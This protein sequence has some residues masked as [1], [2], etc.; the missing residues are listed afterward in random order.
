ME[1]L[2]ETFLWVNSLDLSFLHKTIEDSGWL[3]LLAVGSGG[4]LSAAVALADM[5][6]YWTGKLSIA[7]T[8]LQAATVPSQHEQIVWLLSASGNNVDIMSAFNSLVVRE[9]RKL[10]IICSNPDSKLANAAKKHRFTDSHIYKL[11][12]GKDGFLATNSLL[13][14]ASIFMKAY[15]SIFESS[16]KWN[17]IYEEIT[18]ILSFQEV[19]QGW[20]KTILPLLEKR[21]LIVLYDTNTRSGAFDI[22]SKFTEAALGNVQLA[23]TRNFAHGRH[24]WLAKR[25]Y[26]SSVLSITTN[27]GKRL[28]ERTIKLIPNEIPSVNINLGS[29]P[30]TALLV[31]IIFSLYITQ[32]AGEIQNI[33]PGRPGVPDF[34]RKIYNLHLPKI[35]KKVKID[36]ISIIEQRA[37]ERKAHREIAYLKNNN[38]LE[39]WKDALFAF[40][41]ELST[42]KFGAIIFDYD[43]TFIDTRYRFDNPEDMMLK[44]LECILNSKIKIGFATGRGKSIRESLQSVLPEKKWEDVIIAYY[45]GASIGKLSNNTLPH[46]GIPDTNLKKFSAI[47]D[48]SYMIKNNSQIVIKKNQ[49]SLCISETNLTS[50]IFSSVNELI[51]RFFQNKIKATC[52]AHSIDII[53]YGTSKCS[54]INY[55]NI[56][57]GIENIL[58]IGDQGKWPG[59]DFEMLSERY[60]LSVD[61][62]NSSPETCWNL[63]LEGQRGIATT[64]YYLNS[65]QLA[66]GFFTYSCEA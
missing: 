21:N 33:D 54:L 55:L 56:S 22:E 13:S 30:Q 41:R 43:G 31:S 17:D 57:E 23:D 63:G 39:Y 28:A 60:A 34:G 27:N 11:P 8:A 46:H 50:I 36:D 51:S 42:V 3:N 38:Q 10:S 9:P 1:N 14:Y 25:G 59:N 19:I 15:V 26:E 40:K 7:A 37:I 4:S 16:S 45:N 52:S 44:K 66:D 2:L 64:L 65:L 6:Q 47:L 12:S 58:I 61:T 62:V 29:N 24:H 32:W 5:H 53:T 49:I 48:K 18:H 35:V 20:K